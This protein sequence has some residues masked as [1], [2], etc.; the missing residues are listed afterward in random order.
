M[1]PCLAATLLETLRAF[2][3]DGFA[4]PIHEVRTSKAPRLGEEEKTPRAVMALFGFVDGAHEIG[5]A[6]KARGKTAHVLSAVIPE[7]SLASQASRSKI[8]SHKISG[9]PFA[10]FVPR[11]RDD[12][13]RS[14]RPPKACYVL[15]ALVARTPGSFCTTHATQHTSN[16]DTYHNTLTS[17]W[18]RIFF[19]F[20]TLVDT[21][22]PILF[23]ICFRA[24]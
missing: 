21:R 22:W 19:S 24:R 2:D 3:L 16:T 23:F 15:S 1:F 4:T 6:R 17:S 20:L 12:T 9:C 14:K 8:S 13:M 5:S 7:E 10:Q 18:T 11:A